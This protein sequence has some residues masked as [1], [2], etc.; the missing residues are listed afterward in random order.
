MCTKLKGRA[1]TDFQTREIRNFTQ[2]KRELEV[3]YLSRKSTTHLQLEFNTLK[4]KQG[5]SARTFGLQTNKLAKEL[6]EFIIE[7]RNHTPESKRII[8]DTI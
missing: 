6:Y 2:L 1:I 4:Q 7:E 3:C 8:L 5:E